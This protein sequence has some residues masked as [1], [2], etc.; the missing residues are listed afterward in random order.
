[1]TEITLDGFVGK[2]ETNGEATGT[3]RGHQEEVARLILEVES[4]RA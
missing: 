2:T 1:M 4:G 3:V